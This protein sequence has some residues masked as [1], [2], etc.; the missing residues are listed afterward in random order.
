MRVSKHAER[1]VVVLEV[2]GR[3]GDVIED[4][5]RAIQL[6][7]ADGP[8]G[9]VCDLSAVLNGAE[10]ESVDLLAT[11]GRVCATGLGSLWP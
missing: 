6:A 4:L 8:R 11:A 3:L 2:A 5:D 7:L 10:P 9:V 1:G